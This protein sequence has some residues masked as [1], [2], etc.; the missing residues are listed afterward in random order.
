MGWQPSQVLSFGTQLVQWENKAKV[1]ERKRINIGRHVYTVKLESNE[2][3]SCSVENITRR[4]F[5]HKIH[6]RVLTAI[7]SNDWITSEDLHIIHELRMF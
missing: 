4:S 5:K 3:P 7:H 6:T 1:A 2:S